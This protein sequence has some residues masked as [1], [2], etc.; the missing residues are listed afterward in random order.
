MERK[1]GDW[2]YRFKK[3]DNNFSKEWYVK[4]SESSKS[5]DLGD[6]TF[7]M[8]SSFSDIES[9]LDKKYLDDERKFFWFPPGYCEVSQF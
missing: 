7:G 9:I 2:E 4:H 5:S 3:L 1:I 6:M 8:I